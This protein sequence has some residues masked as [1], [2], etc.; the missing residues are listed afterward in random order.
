AGTL[1]AECETAG[2]RSA[3][4]ADIPQTSRAL[5]GMRAA[6]LDRTDMIAC[7]SDRSGG[8]S[9]YFRLDSLRAQKYLV[10]SPIRLAP[11]AQG[12]LLIW[13]LRRWQTDATSRCR[14][15]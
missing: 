8:I 12:R 7:H 14:S 4:R 10:M 5:G 13:R 11:L 1:G 2:S 15:T 3:R 9:Y 6:H